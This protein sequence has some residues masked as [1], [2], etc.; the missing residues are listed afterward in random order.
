[1]E[2]GAVPGDVRND[3]ILI[4]I[5]HFN[6][7]DSEQ[8]PES[9]M[10]SVI[11]AL[12]RVLGNAGS[13]TLRT[14]LIVTATSM[15]SDYAAFQVQKIVA[16]MSED[17]SHETA[18][19]VIATALSMVG[20]GLILLGAVRDECAATATFKSRLGRTLMSFIFMGSFVLKQMTGGLSS[21]MLATAVK[22]V[23]YVLS[24]D[25]SNAYVYLQDNAGAA[26]NK[27]VALSMAGYG[28]VQFALAELA[29][30]MPLNGAARQAAGLDFSFFVSLLRSATNAVGGIADDLLLPY[31][32]HWF[33]ISRSLGLDSQVCDP[34]A[35]HRNML[36]VTA[37]LRLANSHQLGNAFFSAAAARMT[38]LMA[39]AV[40]MS[41]LEFFF[42]DSELGD[43]SQAR[44]LNVVQAGM[45]MLIYF[46]FVYVC[47]QRPVGAPVQL[48]EIMTP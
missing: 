37:G 26:S 44:A 19:R 5:G 14:G 30:L 17:N 6:E 39:I 33:P 20:L 25:V 48:N 10:R 8:T 11:D 40:F 43:D 18:L 27:S 3:D 31:C 4:E 42:N 47:S 28:T 7:S 38:V 46:P 9:R 2:T 12:I 23:S 41:T 13:V 35:L 1:M 15:L 21:A 24:R 32:K 22:V 16:E 29:N 45:L 36:E 34:E